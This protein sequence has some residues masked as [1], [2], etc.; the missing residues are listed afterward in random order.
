VLRDHLARSSFLAGFGSSTSV[1]I[2]Q[3]CTAFADDR[4]YCGSASCLCLSDTWLD[5][6]KYSIDHYLT[7]DADD[8]RQPPDLDLFPLT[9]G[10]TCLARL[11]QPFWCRVST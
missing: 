8:A 1:T 10:L 11:M 9:L 6:W 2:A 3:S 5:L 7:A 4:A